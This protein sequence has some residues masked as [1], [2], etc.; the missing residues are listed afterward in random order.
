MLRCVALRCVVLCCIALCF[1]LVLVESLEELKKLVTVEPVGVIVAPTSIPPHVQHSQLCAN[2][3]GLCTDT[4]SQVKKLMTMMRE[5][6]LMLL[7][8]GQWNRDI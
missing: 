5:N 8:H 4:L 6:F 1:V 2:L 3:I 7:K